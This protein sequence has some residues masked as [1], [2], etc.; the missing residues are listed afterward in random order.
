[1]KFGTHAFEEITIARN[2]TFDTVSFSQHNEQSNVYF[3]KAKLAI[4]N[5]KKNF[6]RLNQ[7]FF[8][9]LA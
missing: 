1:M 5:L 7:S 4:K 9:P 2:K 6:V 8:K 3:T